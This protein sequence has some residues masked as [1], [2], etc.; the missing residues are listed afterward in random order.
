MKKKTKTTMSLEDLLKLRNVFKRYE[1]VKKVKVAY[2][3]AKNLTITE[4]FE[5]DYKKATQN[6][7]AMNEFEKE[8]EKLLKEYAARDEKNRPIRTP[9]V[10]VPGAWKHE[11]ADELAYECAFEKLQG[12]EAQVEAMKDNEQLQEERKEL[13]ET[14]HEV[15]FY[16]M[17][18]SA[19]PEDE[20]GEIEI[21][22][23]DLAVL[24]KYHIIVDDV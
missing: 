15:E 2:F 23:A 8:K 7:P 22:A 12:D 16:S 11:L 17:P 4:D 5:K 3:I 9:V 10:G 13:L 18:F 1:T 14:E 20:N 6:T 21:M 19:L 24:M